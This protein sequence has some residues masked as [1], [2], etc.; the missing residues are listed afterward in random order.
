MWKGKKKKTLTI[1]G[2]LSSNSN[3]YIL[4]LLASNFESIYTP[5]SYILVHTL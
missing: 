3:N 2:C 1:R 5:L 4:Y